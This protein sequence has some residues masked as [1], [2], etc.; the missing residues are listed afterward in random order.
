MRYVPFM[1]T[2]RLAY[3]YFDLRLIRETITKIT[4][5]F[6]KRALFRLEFAASEQA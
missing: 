4:K 6:T 2:E 5:I 1:E 3:E